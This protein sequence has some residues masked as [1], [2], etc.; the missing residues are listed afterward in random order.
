MVATKKD[1]RIK[2]KGKRVLY[3]FRTRGKSELRYHELPFI[4]L[5]RC[6]RGK[7]INVPKA[8]LNADG[9]RY[10]HTKV[11]KKYIMDITP[12]S[13]ASS[14]RSSARAQRQSGSQTRSREQAVEKQ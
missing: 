4:K 1:L 12:A 10:M 11:I 13:L 9:V 6:N 2:N 3:S 7:I 14:P 5:D 8:I